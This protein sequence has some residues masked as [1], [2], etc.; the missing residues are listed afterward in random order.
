MESEEGFIDVI[1]IKAKTK[2]S[3]S[4]DKAKR[5]RDADVDAFLI[6]RYSQIKSFRPQR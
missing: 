6:A 2:T 4:I 3:Y 5:R 1:D